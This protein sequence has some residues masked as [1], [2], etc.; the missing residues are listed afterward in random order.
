MITISLCMI[1]RN[2]EQFLGKCLESVKDLVDE[3]IIVDTGSTDATKTIAA[4]YTVHINDFD[5]IDD[6]SAARNYSFSLATKDYIMWL[7]ADDWLQELD[8]QKFKELKKVL[9]PNFD[10][11]YMDYYTSFD[12]NG[13]PNVVIKRERLV[14]RS[15]QFQW[16][17]RVHEFL[18]VEGNGLLTDIAVSHGKIQ[19]KI[20]DRNLQIYEAAILSGKKLSNREL[21]FYAKELKNN[22]YHT[23]AISVFQQFL[24][25]PASYIENILEA[26]EQMAVC[27]HEIGDKE[28][29]FMC[30]LKTLEYDSPRADYICRIAYFFQDAGDYEKAISWYQV[31]I[32]TEKPKDR[33]GIVNHL[34]WT[35]L[36]HVNLAICYDK[37]G[38]LEKA[39][40]HNELALR[41]IPDDPNL[42]RNKQ[43]L[44]EYL[45]KGKDES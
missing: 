19:E 21:F 16:H 11:V 44:E 8:Y 12:I 2:E 22:G 26:Y 34:A 7:D 6:F 32:K 31:A 43:L 13:Q 41:F 4:K 38:Q 15:K 9:N 30:L 35:W 39:Y 25:D 45:S 3:I 29:E 40:E 20:T 37:L 1:V 14:K 28:H 18:Q 36:P 23:K 10:V 24:A 33:F 27:Y 42:L 17:E 5:W